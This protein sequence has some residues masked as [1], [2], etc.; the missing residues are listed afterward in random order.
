[1]QNNSEPKL[2][3]L[4]KQLNSFKRKMIKMPYTSVKEMG[5]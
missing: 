5:K 1:M 2:R 4:Y 3:T